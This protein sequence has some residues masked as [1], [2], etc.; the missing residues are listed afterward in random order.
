M[1]EGN[2]IISCTPKE[3]K[4]V[5]LAVGGEL[6]I[7]MAGP[8]GVGKSS[9]VR[10]V[11]KE[12]DAQEYILRLSVLQTF[13]LAGIPVPNLESKETQWMRPEILP[14]EEKIKASGK[15]FAILNL[16]EMASAPPALQT[17][18]QQI[19]LDRRIGTFSLPGPDL[20]W[21]VGSG[22]RMTDKA[23]TYKLPSPVA[24]RLVYLDV[25]ADYDA[26]REWAVANGEHPLVL[27]YHAQRQGINLAPE[28]KAEWASSAFPTPRSWHMVS[29]IMHRYDMS[30]RPGYEGPPISA[31]AR[32][33]AIIGAI[34]PIG[35][36]FEAYCKVEAN[37]PDVAGML[38]G[39]VPIVE[40]QIAKLSPDALWVVASSA[41]LLISEKNVPNYIR[42]ISAL[43]KEFALVSFKDAFNRAR[44]NNIRSLMTSQEAMK[45][46]EDNLPYFRFDN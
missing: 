45:F 29:T 21:M 9:I 23:V 8:P 6:P 44:A 20:L 22:N 13:D 34:G 42:L 36:D 43:P 10:E 7:Y 33:L 15:K 28:I 16:D 3:A 1:S 27:A 41:A 31:K 19:L 46:A 37:L 14:T 26:W 24:D 40:A 2:G 30:K 17:G 32:K 5:I 12:M 35:I 4:E 39:A 11:C 38:D 18:A 25:H